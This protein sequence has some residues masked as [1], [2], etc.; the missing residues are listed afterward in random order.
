M[1]RS[2]YRSETTARSIPVPGLVVDPNPGDLVVFGGGRRFHRVEPIG[3]ETPR[4]TYGGFAASSKD[5]DEVN[6]WA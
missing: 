1:P 2:K 4:I 6:C 3:G 5:G